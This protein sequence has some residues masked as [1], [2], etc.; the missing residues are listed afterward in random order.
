MSLKAKT[1]STAITTMMSAV[2]PAR[3]IPEEV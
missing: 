1:A 2:I 3:V